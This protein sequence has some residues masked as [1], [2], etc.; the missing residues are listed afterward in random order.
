MLSTL[1]SICLPSVAPLLIQGSLP[2]E[3]IQNFTHSESAR[4]LPKKRES[5]SQGNI[6][7]CYHCLAAILF[8][9]ITRENNP[10][11]QMDPL[12]FLFFADLFSGIK[13]L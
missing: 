11:K 12:L 9:L 13:Y 5:L 4:D 8:S 10:S 3:V 7:L 1:F 6:L 2:S